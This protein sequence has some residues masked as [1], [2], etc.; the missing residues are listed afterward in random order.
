M[1]YHHHHRHHTPA[2][3]AAAAP[4][5]ATAANPATAMPVVDTDAVRRPR[6]YSLPDL[7]MGDQVHA[8]ALRPQQY[9]DY[10]HHDWNDEDLA[11]SWKL[12][13]KLKNGPLKAGGKGERLEYITWRIWW[14]RKGMLGKAHPYSIQWEKDATNLYALGPLVS[15]SN[16]YP[17]IVPRALATSATPPAAPPMAAFLATSRTVHA[18]RQAVTL[19][20]R[21]CLKRHSLR[22]LLTRPSPAERRA[23]RDRLRASL[24]SLAAAAAAA[25]AAATTPLPAPAESLSDDGGA[26][27][28]RRARRKSSTSESGRSAK[29]RSAS[30]DA[31]VSVAASTASSA[32]PTPRGG[33]SAA[34]NA[35][36][37][38]AVAAALGGTGGVRFNPM[39]DERI[40]VGSHVVEDRRRQSRAVLMA[41]RDGED[42]DD[43]DEE[44]DGGNGLLAPPSWAAVA[45]TG[46]RHA[47]SVGRGHRHHHHHVYVDDDDE[48]EEDEDVVMARSSNSRYRYRSY[49]DDN[50]SEPR[51]SDND[52]E[53]EDETGSV[54]LHRH[55]SHHDEDDEYDDYYDDDDDEDEDD[56]DDDYY[57]GRDE[58]PVV[59]GHFS[60]PAAASSLPVVSLSP[61]TQLPVHS[62]RPDLPP[63]IIN[64]KP[65]SRTASPA[66]SATDPPSDPT[67][68]DGNTN[69]APTS[70]LVPMR[71]PDGPGGGGAISPRA[72]P[73]T[74]HL[75]LDPIQDRRDFQVLC[76]LVD[77]LL[78]ESESEGSTEATFAPSD[79]PMPMPRAASPA[80]AD[81]VAA[82]ALSPPPPA[83]N[84]IASPGAA[85]SPT[86][87]VN[88]TSPTTVPTA[89]NGTTAAAAEPAAASTPVSAS[90]SLAPSP[91]PP[92][93]GD[94]S[95][96]E[97]VANVRDVM[98]W[99]VQV[100]SG[101]AN[102]PL[103]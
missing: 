40:F 64:G 54:I 86:G 24:V 41:E 1:G 50:A 35:D 25:A 77:D 92:V 82:R 101:S 20:K 29:R 100:L 11:D 67:A 72:W 42:V 68:W 12:V 103:P 75:R 97:V 83:V 62:L 23:L 94:P 58:L 2:A 79:A 34:A 89:T 51:S 87:K 18:L 32:P 70:P 16:P 9:V 71:S 57:D 96:G 10:L 95:L 93:V 85:A 26:A 28:R 30:G 99:I 73:V 8:A 36:A 3:H 76:A 49:E 6:S 7:T 81:T 21:G 65:P 78:T 22:D 19:A 5:P 13:T 66:V 27:V 4:A 17:E 39:V 74:P 52:D 33:P 43:E 80:D 37:A 55:G 53:D 31:S 63:L 46:T 48:Q 98:S 14:Q 47:G 60:F 44:E 45:A 88:G 15:R 84:G 59:P 38:A 69:A 91:V 90:A 56:E 102:G 61:P